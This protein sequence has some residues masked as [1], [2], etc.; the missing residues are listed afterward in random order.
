MHRNFQLLDIKVFGMARSKLRV[1]SASF[2]KTTGAR[3]ALVAASAALLSAC[4]PS[5]TQNAKTACG[6]VK[7][8]I[9]EYEASISNGGGPIKPLQASALEKLREALPYAA[10]AAGSDGNYQALQI[11]LSESSRVP[12][13]RLIPALKSQCSSG[14]LDQSQ[15]VPPSNIQG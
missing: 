13:A 6:Y 12:E 8:S 2:L 5:A 1:P 3:L 7:A 11:T 14:P 9:A 15:Y 10:I 4:A